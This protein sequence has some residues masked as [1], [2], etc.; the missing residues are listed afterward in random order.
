MYCQRKTKKGQCHR[1]SSTSSSG[2][3]VK[4]YCWQH[5]GGKSKEDR[6][7]PSHSATLY[8]V[9]EQLEGNDGNM[10]EII[11][12]S[13]GIHRWSKVKDLSIVKKFS[14]TKRSNKQNNK[15]SNKQDINQKIINIMTDIIKEKIKL[16]EYNDY[17][18]RN[19]ESSKFNKNEEYLFMKFI[20]KMIEEDNLQMAEPMD[21]HDK[22]GPFNSLIDFKNN[23]AE[24]DRYWFIVHIAKN[25]D[26]I[27][28][29]VQASRE[30]NIYGFGLYYDYQ[31]KTVIFIYENDNNTLM[32]LGK[33]FNKIVMSFGKW[34][35]KHSNID[36]DY[37]LFHVKY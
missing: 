16:K 25:K 34:Q 1:F 6:P 29:D 35:N 9:G 36:Y 8:G 5:I 27:F 19:N 33:H 17:W 4:K 20:E 12:T 11:Q 23:F 18:Y 3:L 28:M 31:S 30:Y 26:G 7:S 13:N 24:I 37:G 15:P 10:W 32:G 21:F 2:G 22:V 14:K